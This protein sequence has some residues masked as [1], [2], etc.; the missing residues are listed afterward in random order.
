[1]KSICLLAQFLTTTNLIL[2]E[3][4]F[5]DNNLSFFNSPSRDPKHS[6]ILNIENSLKKEKS[7]SSCFTW[8]FY[9]PNME[10]RNL[11]SREES[12]FIMFCLSW[13]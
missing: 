2:C 3:D 8:L 5:K 12:I 11:E 13:L 10:Y 7:K 1:M 9:L 4:G 6:Q